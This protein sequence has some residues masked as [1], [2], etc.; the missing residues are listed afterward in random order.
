MEDVFDDGP[1]QADTAF[2]V[3][4]LQ[5]L[6]PLFLA[7]FDFRVVRQ[8]DDVDVLLILVDGGDADEVGLLRIFSVRADE[9][10]VERLIGAGLDEIIAAGRRR[11][12]T[13]GLSRRTGEVDIGRAADEEDGHGSDDGQDAV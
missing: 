13:V 10:H 4:V 2:S 5:F 8:H 6:D 9:E 12:G 7:P 3:D 11:I 1:Y